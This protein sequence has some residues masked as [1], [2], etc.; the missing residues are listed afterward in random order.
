MS[1]SGKTWT[2]LW[3]KHILSQSTAGSVYLPL[4][5]LEWVSI[6]EEAAGVAAITLLSCNFIYSL[7]IGKKGM[8]SSVFSMN[9]CFVQF[10]IV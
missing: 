4:K 3:R 8:K 1:V 10:S 7:D 9:H 5:T 6:L 2:E